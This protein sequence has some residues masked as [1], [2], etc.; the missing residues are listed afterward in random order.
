[1]QTVEWISWQPPW[2]D[3]G[4]SYETQ[5]LVEPAD[6]G[7]IYRPKCP[8]TLRLARSLKERR[9]PVLHLKQAEKCPHRETG[10][11]HPAVQFPSR[12]QTEH[13]HYYY[14]TGPI[15]MRNASP[16]TLCLENQLLAS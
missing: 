12:E 2:K 1:M 16:P 3:D 6:L 8:H 7:A 15:E 13:L 9:K 4:T 11:S 5:A 10:V 14:K